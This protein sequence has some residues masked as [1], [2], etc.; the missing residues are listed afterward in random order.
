MQIADNPH[1]IA[2]AGLDQLMR[3]RE[4]LL[5]AGFHEPTEM[6]SRSWHWRFYKPL[7]SLTAFIV[8]L[9][10]YDNHVDV[11][12]GCAST[13][14]TLMAN[15][16]D[17]LTSLGVS[18][19]DITLRAQCTIRDAADEEQAASTIRQ[20]HD[21]FR[22]VEKDELLALAKE[23]RKTFIQQLAVRLKPLG[24]KKKGNK[25]RREM[26]QGLTL[27]FDL[28]KSSYSD[29][30]YFNVDLHCEELVGFGCYS[31]R[32]SPEGYADKKWTMDWQ[33]ISPEAL[34]AFLD[35]R[36]LPHLTWLIGTPYDALGADPAVWEKCFCQRNHCQSCWVQK[37][38]WEANQANS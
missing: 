37:N 35:E 30:Y 15:D 31:H 9:K 10:G 18:D 8:N 16:S 32:V 25:W 2:Q 29:V 14:F 21:Q 20:M 6:Y 5:A 7:T 36:L 11:T 1:P 34:S 13:A 3:Y 27:A 17:A 23:K 4:Q 33:L 19:A 28:Q 24:F 12:Y 38:V 22:S 26:P